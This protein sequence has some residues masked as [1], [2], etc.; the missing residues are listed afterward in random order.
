MFS[1]LGGCSRSMFLC[2]A[3]ISKQINKKISDEVKPRARNDSPVK[4]DVSG[5]Q[6]SSM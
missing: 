6:D 1:A 3:R 2:A 4:S 5:D